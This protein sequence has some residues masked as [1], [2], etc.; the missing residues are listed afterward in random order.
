MA[1]AKITQL[2][3]LTTVAD[4]DLL[5][6]VDD[7]SGSP[8]TKKITRANLLA[9][10]GGAWTLVSYSTATAAS[11]ITISSLDLATDKRYKVYAKYNNKTSTGQAFYLRVN[12][13]GTSIYRG[14]GR[15]SSYGASAS[16]EDRSWTG[17]TYMRLDGANT[18][19]SSMGEI[20]I[21]L[22]ESDGTNTRIFM[23][24]NTTGAGQSTNTNYIQS[25]V[26]SGTV[27]GQ[28]NLT[29]LTFTNDSG[30]TTD[31]DWEVWVLK[32]NTA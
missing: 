27:D 13:L 4:E 5:A 32:P 17:Q 26:G 22:L 8:V 1:D 20:D 18:Y 9:G 19:N 2:T 23:S 31:Q 21:S 24:F 3:E 30:A 15:R 25:F 28:T 12:G 11:S 6:I 10:V 14:M 7:P 16:F 29:S